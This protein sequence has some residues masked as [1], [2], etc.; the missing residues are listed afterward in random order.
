MDIGVSYKVLAKPYM[1]QP[2][3]ITKAISPLRG[4]ISLEIIPLH[5]RTFSILV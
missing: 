1:V 3:A 2:I 5:V 4:G